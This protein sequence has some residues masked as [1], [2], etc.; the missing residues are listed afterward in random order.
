MGEGEEGKGNSFSLLGYIGILYWE[1]LDFILG[2]WDLYLYKD[3]S[4]AVREISDP[5]ISQRRL[6]PKHK[7]T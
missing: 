3:F 5:T 4:P 6:F 7:E 2:Y 1:Y